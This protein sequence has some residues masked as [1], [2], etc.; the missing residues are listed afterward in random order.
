[1]APEQSGSTA[2]RKVTKLG[3]FWPFNSLKKVIIIII[4]IIII[5]STSTRYNKQVTI[6]QDR[7]LTGTK[8]I[9]KKQEIRKIN[10]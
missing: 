6:A 3:K 1:M 9:M 8:T 7:T 2:E 5:Y 4:I 10:T